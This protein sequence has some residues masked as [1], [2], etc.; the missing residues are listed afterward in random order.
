MQV[1]EGINPAVLKRTA[2]FIYKKGGVVN[3]TAGRRNWKKRWFVIETKIYETFVGYEF[4][5]FET[6]NGKLKGSVDLTN[7]EVFCED[8]PRLGKNSRFDFHLLLGTGNSLQLSCED[9][10][11]REEWLE[12]LN[13][14][15][16]YSRKMVRASA[17]TL[18]GYDPMY[19][20]EEQIYKVGEDIAHNCQAYGPGLFGAEVGQ[21]AQFVIQTHDL[22][23]N[24]LVNGGM[25]FTATLTD[26]ECMYYLRI[27]DNND[28]TYA[29]YYVLSRPGIYQ[30]HIRI[31]DEHDIY[32]SP[33]EVEILPSK[34]MPDKCTAE[35]EALSHVFPGV[36]SSFTITARDLYS[37]QK[38]KGG[39]A[40]EVGVMGAAQLKSLQDNGDGTYL[41]SFLAQSPAELNY[42]ASN[43]LM[44]QVTLNGKHIFGS[45]FRPVIEELSPEKVKPITSQAPRSERG[46]LDIS[47]FA[48]KTKFSAPTQDSPMDASAVPSGNQVSGGSPGRG[49][50]M[51]AMEKLQAARNRTLASNSSVR[52]DSGPVVQGDA[53]VDASQESR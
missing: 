19:E 30:L 47:A 9:Y 12:T 40:F 22:M 8:A 25:P 35:G 14:V 16:A 24:A 44:I 32:G 39:D 50:A 37:N 49:A 2:G 51:S 29:A 6:P 53:S 13:M 31:N 27:S 23:G 42:Y 3:V 15:I 4:K 20:D 41:C 28:G 18:D 38:R 34:T 33:F 21:H 36:V 5:Y 11:E 45:P 52:S 46:I 17:N 26:S 10:R 1:S 48:P 43:T 7:V